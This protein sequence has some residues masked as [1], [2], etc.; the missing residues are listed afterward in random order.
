MGLLRGVP[1]IPV[2]LQLTQPSLLLFTARS[3]EDVPF[4]ALEPWAVKPGVGLEYLEPPMETSIAE[5]PS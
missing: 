2:A 3:C 5:I 1:K 4:L